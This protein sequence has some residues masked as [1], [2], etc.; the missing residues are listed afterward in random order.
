[1]RRKINSILIV[2]SLYLWVAGCNPTFNV[3]DIDGPSPTPTQ[4][5][6][7]DLQIP[8]LR[9]LVPNILIPPVMAQVPT[10]ADHGSQLYYQICLACHGDWGQGLTDEWRAQ[11]G[12][13]SNCFQSQCHGL[14]VPD[15]GFW[16]PRVIPPVLG[17]GSLGSL[18][19]A[20]EMHEYIERTMPWWNPGS[21][22]NEDAWQLTAYLLRERGELDDVVDVD[23][24]IAT[25]IKLHTKT[26]LPDDFRPGVSI[27]LI[28]LTFSFLAMV[29]FYRPG[30]KDQIQNQTDDLTNLTESQRD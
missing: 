13:D 7:A 22:T 17:V 29:V 10:N 30:N 2:F 19:N 1:M 24:S 4:Q 21:L 8:G 11:W 20:S 14:N 6:R 3:N 23:E 15:N 16:I 12:D 5:A 28:A 9:P 26:V 27:L 18:S 25:I